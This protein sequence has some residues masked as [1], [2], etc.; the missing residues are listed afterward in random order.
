LWW[1]PDRGH[2]PDELPAWRDSLVT[3]LVVYVPPQPEV[4]RE[5]AELILG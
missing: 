5:V 3:T 2:G 4:L 1:R